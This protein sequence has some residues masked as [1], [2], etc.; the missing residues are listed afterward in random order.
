MELTEW[1][2]LQ[3]TN[4]CPAI[5]LEVVDG[6]KWGFSFAAAADVVAWGDDVAAAVMML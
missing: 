2:A 5:L 1:C 3:A 4:N 6:V